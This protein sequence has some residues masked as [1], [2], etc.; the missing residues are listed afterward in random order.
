MSSVTPCEAW[1]SEINKMSKSHHL[2]WFTLAPSI[3][4]YQRW[5]LRCSARGVTWRCSSPL[6]RCSTNSGHTRSRTTEKYLTIKTRKYLM[7]LCLLSIWTWGMRGMRDDDKIIFDK[8]FLNLDDLQ[9]QH[10]IS[11][12]T[13]TKVKLWQLQDTMKI[14]ERK[15]QN[16]VHV[17]TNVSTCQCHALLVQI[18]FSGFGC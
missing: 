14:N 5:Y 13:Q 12:P 8:K 6:A 3:N 11:H 9:L 7:L 4:S 18:G 1:H 16:L 10:N 15:D 17:S 2:S